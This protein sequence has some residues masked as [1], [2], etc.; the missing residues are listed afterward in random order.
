MQTVQMAADAGGNVNVSASR[1]VLVEPLSDGATYPVVVRRNNTEASDQTVLQE[2]VLSWADLQSIQV[3][4]CEPGS[5]WLVTTFEPLVEGVGQPDAPTRGVLL[6]RVDFDTLVEG[7]N[8][9]GGMLDVSRWA[10]V[11]VRAHVPGVDDATGVD[12]YLV[13]EVDHCN[14]VAA[15]AIQAGTEDMAQTPGA[16]MVQVGD[17]LGEVTATRRSTRAGRPGT[18]RARFAVTGGPPVLDAGLA[19]IEVWGFR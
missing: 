3:R 11:T 9:A 13:V 7:D 2:R 15:D 10:A 16:A 14:G 19:R 4:G 1:G 12:V 6:R 18:V 17:G 8:W 5:K